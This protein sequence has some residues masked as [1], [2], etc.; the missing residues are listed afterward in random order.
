MGLRRLLLRIG[1]MGLP[2]LL[3]FAVVVVVDPYAFFDR[4]RLISAELKRKNL[5]HS[6]RTMPFSNLLWKMIEFRRQP[7]ERVLIGDSRLAYFDL[8][9]LNKTTGQRW[10]NFGVPGG[11]HRTACDVFQYVDGTAKLKEVWLQVSFRSMA[12]G[13]NYDL[14]DEPSA[15][16]QSA[17]LYLTN[18][19]VLEATALAIYGTLW[20]NRVSYDV[21]A[22]DHWQ[23]V[24]RMEEGIA[25]GFVMDTSH[26]AHFAEIAQ[27][28][29]RKG[30][31][32]TFVEYPTTVGVQRIYS[33]ASLDQAMLAHRT[34]MASIG[35]YVFLDVDGG[36]GA[37]STLYRDPLH[38]T[39]AGQR[40][41][42]N[43]VLSAR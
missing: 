13:S 2:F 11:N 32:L 5:G 25:D 22:P 18:R 8:D 12:R 34:R 38:L 40:L 14:Y 23:Q 29:A 6:G 21:L 42:V 4:S 43:A 31:R 17:P 7:V 10:Y 41:L 39:A 37:D 3:L 24:L 36:I 28:C 16:A 19:R 26:Y 20:P 9:H 33:Q 30:V 15:V 27:R 1:I 35:R